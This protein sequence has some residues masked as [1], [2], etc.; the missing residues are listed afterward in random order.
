[1]VTQICFN[2]NNITIGR[3]S[4]YILIMYNQVII[5]KGNDSQEIGVT[6][7]GMQ[8]MGVERSAHPSPKKCILFID[9]DEQLLA[10]LELSLQGLGFR[11]LTSSNGTSGLQ[12]IGSQS[13]DLVILD[14]K[15]PDMD[16]EAV[17]HE[18]RR[19]RPLMP[20]IMYSGA[21]EKVPARVLELVDEFVSKQEPISNL[22]HYIPRVVARADRPRRALQRHRI[23]VPFLVIDDVAGGVVI[24]GESLDLSEAGMGGVVHTELS[25]GR[26]VRLEIAVPPA[27]ALCTHATVRYKTGARHGFQFLDL[28]TTQAKS[29]RAAYS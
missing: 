27:A 17:A 6:S 18:L 29:I 19:L 26:V 8:L 9:D 23:Q 21:L 16:G 1:M 24:H 13:V 5:S 2:F 25:A 12:I 28:T 14:Y 22:V 7:Y 10:L 4:K 20:I 15:M 11:V 3:S